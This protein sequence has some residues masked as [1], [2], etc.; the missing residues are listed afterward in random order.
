VTQHFREST[1]VVAGAASGRTL[2]GVFFF[3]DLSPLRVRISR[4][5]RSLL[6]YVTNVCALVGGVYAVTGLVDAF[7]HGALKKALGRKAA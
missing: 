2:P 4:S 7:A 6:H 3:Y 5:R 1:P